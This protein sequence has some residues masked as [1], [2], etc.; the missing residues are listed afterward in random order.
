[1][2]FNFV[3]ISSKRARSPISQ[4]SNIQPAAIKNIFR[5]TFLFTSITQTPF[6]IEYGGKKGDDSFDGKDL[7]VKDVDKADKLFRSIEETMDSD[8]GLKTDRQRFHD[9]S[10]PDIFLRKL[11]NTSNVNGFVLR[12]AWS[13]FL[14]NAR[15]IEIAKTLAQLLKQ[16]IEGQSLPECA[17]LKVKDIGYQDYID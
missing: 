12:I 15:K 9:T 16:Q 13:V 7:L 6:H 11:A 14:W 3:T 8:Y 2:P 10:S 17:D 4:Y 1:M 5:K